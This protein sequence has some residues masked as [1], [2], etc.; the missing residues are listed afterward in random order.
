[1]T[2][3]APFAPSSP[4]APQRRG[5]V[6][7]A[8]S[9]WPNGNTDPPPRTKALVISLV[10]SRQCATSCLGRTR[11]H[12]GNSHRGWCGV[13]RRTRGG[14][15]C[16]ARYYH[17]TLQRFVSED[18]IE[19]GGGD[20]NL[21]G[22]VGNN[23]LRYVD[24]LG[25]EWQAVIG[26]SGSLGGGPFLVGGLFGGGGT[27]IIFTSSGQIG[28]QFT[29][30]ASAGVGLYAGVGVQA[31]GGYSRCPTKPGLSVNRVGQ[32]DLNAGWGPVN[33]GVS[34]QYDPSAAGIQI[35]SGVARAGVG[36]G[37]QASAGVSQVV[38]IGTP[39]LFGSGRKDGCQ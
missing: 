19:F 10:A 16:R 27:N 11:P 33:R 8:R 7:P 38:T 12:R 35:Q 15:Y 30:T 21:Y 29:A 2:V 39:A 1:M 36:F 25:L 14:R 17:P 6:L 26:V 22:Y 37:I 4:A 28:V 9:R 34:A 20:V 5:A 3:R 32:V 23:P 31:G 18:P 24:P 13:S